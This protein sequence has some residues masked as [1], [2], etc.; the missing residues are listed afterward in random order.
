MGLQVGRA[1]GTLLSVCKGRRRAGDAEF[2]LDLSRFRAVRI[3]NLPI[4]DW[5][6][7]YIHIHI[8]IY[9]CIDIHIHIC[10]SLMSIVACVTV[11]PN[12]K[13]QNPQS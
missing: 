3:C 1:L 2:R 8:Y 10:F 4:A 9:I 13:P 6:Y 12:L 5:V 11:S 7:M